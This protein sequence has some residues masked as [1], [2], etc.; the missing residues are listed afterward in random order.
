MSRHDPDNEQYEE[1]LTIE[2]RAQHAVIMASLKAGAPQNLAVI[3]N[4]LDEY[5]MDL[6]SLADLVE[7][8]VAG[9][10]AL[11]PII[12]DLVWTEAQDRAKTE[13][14]RREREG[15]AADA[16]ARAE[17]ARLNREYA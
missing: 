1:A 13:M 14:A 17:R 15:R 7:K 6:H 16:D 8:S 10:N 11:L 3:T 2:A 12:T 4:A 9:E 5:L